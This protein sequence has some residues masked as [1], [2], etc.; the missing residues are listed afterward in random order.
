MSPNQPEV[1]VP[2][3]RHSLWRKALRETGDRTKLA[4][5]LPGMRYDCDRPLLA[6]TGGLLDT[7]GY[8]LIRFEFRFAEDPAFAAQEDSAQLALIEQECAEIAD[9]P[10]ALG[11]YQEV[12]L[13][14]KSLGTLAMAAALARWK[15]PLVRA[16]FLTPSLSGTALLG[17]MTQ[18]SQES[19]VVI[20]DRDPSFQPAYMERLQQ[21]AQLRLV[22][23]KG[24]DHSFNPQPKRSETDMV[25]EAVGAIGDWLRARGAT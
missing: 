4:I 6:R 18:L 1:A 5:L 11:A 17:Q 9:L 24:A 15:T 13:V 12:L 19:L 2:F 22:V 23:I 10:A 25:E 16:I 14:G 8:D 3:T 20:G 21:L 7:L